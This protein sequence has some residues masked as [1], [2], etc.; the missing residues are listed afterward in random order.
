V[1]NTGL[2]PLKNALFALLVAVVLAGCSGSGDS[3]T[4]AT[5]AEGFSS[6]FGDFSTLP[7]GP[8]PNRFSSGQPASLA[9]TLDD[10]MQLRVIGGR[11]T[12]E[13]RSDGPAG[14]YLR[15]PDLGRQIVRI[16]M[17][18]S[19]EASADGGPGIAT[20]GITSAPINPVDGKG[21]AMP[22]HFIARR[23]AWGFAVSPGTG[24]GGT[25]LITLGGGSFDPPLAEDGS[26]HRVEIELD[27]PDAT[28]HLPD[29]STSHVSDAR[30]ASWAGRFGFFGV[31]SD[32]GVSDSRVGLLRV[33]AST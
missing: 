5:L 1:R 26:V 22:V 16:G 3:A 4:A 20:M 21:T 7:D 32:L 24:E 33:W 31:Y 19:V 11:L 2:N 10:A 23:D 25:Q 30:I 15:T 6:L 12:F 18:W 8:A 29:G 9:P 13:P 28:V 14:G 17:E 27:G